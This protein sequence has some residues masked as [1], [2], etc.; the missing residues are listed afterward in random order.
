MYEENDI[1]EFIRAGFGEL[2]TSSL[3]SVQRGN[4]VCS[5]WQP[6]L[7]EEEK[8]SINREVTMEEIKHAMWSLKIFKAL[9]LDGLHVGF[10]QIFRLIVSSSVIDE[11]KKVFVSKKIPEVFN[12]THIALIPKI[13]GPKTL[14]NYRLISL[15][16]TVYK[17]VTKIIVARLR[18]LLGKLISPLQTA[19]VPGRKGVDNA[20]IAQEIIYTLGRK[21]GRVGYMALKID[22]E[23]A[24]DKFEWSFIREMLNRVNLPKDL[25]DII[26]SC[27][28]TMS[29][30]ILF[31]EEALESIFHSRGIRQG[32][33]LSPYLFILCMDFLSQ[34]IEEKCN[35]K[36]WQPVKAS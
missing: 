10:Y 4:P 9:G 13:Q 20:I 5:Q 19:F 28:S 12:R 18:P 14:G 29:T 30:S 11:V 22:L 3:V 1:K 2:F 23:K 17:I 27:V 7:T 32:D 33:P 36:L 34:L 6:R 16:N 25:I 8:L 35:A 21:K 24:Y 15:Y 31:N 26:M